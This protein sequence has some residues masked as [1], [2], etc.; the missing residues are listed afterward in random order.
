MIPETKNHLNVRLQKMRNALRNLV[1]S[2]NELL[3]VTKTHVSPVTDLL[4][5]LFFCLKVKI[6]SHL[7]LLKQRFDSDH[8]SIINRMTQKQ[9]AIK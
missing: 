4:P 8:I 2:R 3:N 1:V 7:T 5:R 9:I 6:A